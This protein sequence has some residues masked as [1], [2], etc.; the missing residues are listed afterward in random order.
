MPNKISANGERDL[1]KVRS[2]FLQIT[3][4]ISFKADRNFIK[5]LM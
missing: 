5:V 3:N 4:E 2:S 1:N